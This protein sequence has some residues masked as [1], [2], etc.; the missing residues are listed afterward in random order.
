MCKN[1][2]KLLA[3]QQNSSRIQQL[4]K[5]I[6]HEQV[7]FIPGMQGFFNIC[8]SIN[9]IHIN[10]LKYQNHVIISVDVEKAFDKIQPPFM[11]KTPQRAGIEGTYLNIIMPYMINP[12]ETLSSMVKN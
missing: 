11:I 12:Q 6:H 5:I 8:K 3:I 4:I 9:V 1:P 2:Q 10:K 7:D